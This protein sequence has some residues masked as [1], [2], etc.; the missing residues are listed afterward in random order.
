MDSKQERAMNK[1]TDWQTR[2]DLAVS[3][4]KSGSYRAAREELVLVLQNC[5]DSNLREQALS[6]LRE[7]PQPSMGT[8][9]LAY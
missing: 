6:V 2:M 5:P 9:I 7:A 8:M 1:K 4:Y 3:Y